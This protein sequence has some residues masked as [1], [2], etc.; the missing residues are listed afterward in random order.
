MSIAAATTTVVALTGPASA[1]TRTVKDPRGDARPAIDITRASFTNHGTYVQARLKVRDLRWR[2][3]FTMY[4]WPVD[5]EEGQ[6]MISL[7]AHHDH[8]TTVTAG[9]EDRGVGYESLDCAGLHAR[10]RAKKD[11]VVLRVPRSCI[12][13][14]DL[15]NTVTVDAEAD[16][17]TKH[18]LRTDQVRAR[19]VRHS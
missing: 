12:P 7:T 15:A 6:V 18:G 5:P 16:I 13:G 11:V 1:E 3:R 8:T 19:R 10:Y 17:S 14:I 2:G 9:Y 4:A